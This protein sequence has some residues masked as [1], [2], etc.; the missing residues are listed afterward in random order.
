MEQKHSI[1]L[2]RYADYYNMQ[3]ELEEL[4]ESSRRKETFDSLTDLIF[5]EK[6]ILLA[7]RN[8]RTNQGSLTPG[9][10]N[11]NIEN[12][13]T[14]TPREFIDNVKYI[15]F[16]TPHGYRPKPAR[17]VEIPKSNGKTRPLSIPC[18][19]DRLIQQAIKQVLEPI[20]EAKFSPNSYAFRPDISIENAL[21]SCY[22]L[23]QLQKCNYV[24]ELDIKSYFDN[25][26][27]S[28]LIRQLWNIGIR[29]KKLLYIIKRII[30]SPVK[31]QDK[32]IIIPQKGIPQGGILSPLL[33]N[34]YLN[35]FDQWIDSQWQ[36]N[37]LSNKYAIDRTSKGKGIDKGTAY[38]KMRK[39]NLKEIYIVRYADDIRLFAKDYTAAKK[40]LIAANSWLR[41]RLR[42][43]LSTEKTRIVNTK[44]KYMKFLGFKIKLKEKS[45]KFVV[46]SHIDDKTLSQ[47]K[48]KLKSQIKKIATTKNRNKQTTYDEVRRYNLMIVGIQEYYKYATEVQ[49]DLDKI[50]WDLMKC[51]K[52][53]LTKE[54]S[55][56]WKKAGRKLTEF[57]S[58]RYGKSKMLRYVDCGKH[59]EPI[60][61]LSYIKTKHPMCRNNLKSRYSKDYKNINT[62]EI[63]SNKHILYHLI[64]DSSYDSSVKLM[65]NKI[66]L[67]SAQKGKCAITR[68]VF[69][70]TKD[71]N[72][73]HIVPRF[74]NGTDEYSNLVLIKPI[75][76]KLIHMTNEES[77]N[78]YLKCLKLS[79]KE[80]EKINYYRIKCNLREIKYSK[81]I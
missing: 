41:E 48:E 13:E 79:N 59:C 54:K 49:I 17:R 23:L 6:N 56:R 29:D 58:K 14:L 51:F 1:N 61:P 62:N 26:D 60:Y 75:I 81:N 37:P 69:A 52:N 35:E 68:E 20:C 45:H 15:V 28:K 65:N 24:I 34:V 7:Y 67:F 70:N 16:G 30:K 47:E 72:I 73:H 78:Q 39:S 19:W 66:S 77:I 25:I 32:E 31:L 2:L 80:I 57:E 53:R 38:K 9:T 5:S 10:D 46:V 8:I 42:L 64:E 44:Q 74:L 4:Y 40:I 63:N 11:L 22:K 18:I 21:G 3:D 33:S 76:H 12:I 43:T 55:G 50:N 27:H 36:N 71:I